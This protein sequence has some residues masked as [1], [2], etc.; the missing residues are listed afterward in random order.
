MWPACHCQPVSEPSPPR[1][2][3]VNTEEAPWA[4]KGDRDCGLGLGVLATG[5]SGSDS[6]DRHLCATY[7]A[8]CRASQAPRTRGRGSARQHSPN[9]HRAGGRGPRETSALPRFWPLGR[10]GGG[11]LQ[12]NPGRRP[13]LLQVPPPWPRKR[14]PE[15]LSQR[16][17]NSHLPMRSAQGP[18][19][20]C[21]HHR[22]PWTE[23]A[24][25]RAWPLPPSGKQN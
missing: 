18:E 24:Q 6:E 19:P 23:R 15:L 16:P 22:V 9:R 25:T 21:G 8:P 12:E 17:T 3:K 13:R 20:G 11:V 10:T 4:G 1:A 7:Q 14:A 2:A 5:H